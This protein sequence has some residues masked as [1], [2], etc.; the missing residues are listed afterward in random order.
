MKRIFLLII[1]ILMC[2]M[3]YA[4]ITGTKNIPADYPTLA[5]AITDL[6]TQG[7]GYGGV[8]LNLVAG[9][10]ETAPAGGYSI[11]TLTGTALSPITII[12]NG[13]TITSYSP[14]A[15][16]LLN[17]AIFKIIGVDYITIQGFTMQ[18]NTAN[19]TFTAGTNNMTEF[20]IALFYATQTDGAK[21]ITIQNNIISLNRLY[22]NS[23]GIYS[24]VRHSSTVMTTAADITS[25][26]GANDNTHIY[27]NTIT[28]VNIGIAIVGST[29]TANMNTGIDI[30][31]TSSSTANTIS[32]FG[33]T[34]S[35]SSF[36]S[37]SGSVMG[38]YV[39]NCLNTNI[40]YNSISCPGLNTAGT[41]YGVF[42]QSTGPAPT[43]G[44]PISN[45]VT[46]NNISMKSGVLSGT[47]YGMRY[48]AGSA[49][50]S[51]DLSYN[52]FSNFGYIGAG[53]GTIYG[54]YASAAGNLQNVTYNTFTNLS[55]NTTGTVYLL[56]VNGLVSL[57]TS[58]QIVHHNSI[59]TAFTK[60]SAGGIV[61][62]LYNAGASSVGTASW[63]NNNFS[64][65]TLTG[66]TT[67]VLFTQNDQVTYKY[68]HDNI[69]NNITGGT[70]AITGLT[71][72]NG[73]DSIYNNTFSGITNG[74]A[75]TGIKNGSYD[76]KTQNI[77]SN[78]IHGF[79]STGAAA[80]YGIQSAVSTTGAV[81]NIYKNNIYDL[82]DA[83]ATAASVVYGIYVSAGVTQNIYNNFISDLRTP[84]AN[85]ANPLAGIWLAS[86][87]G[88]TNNVFY[89]T[90]FLSGSSSGALFGSS[91]LYTTTAPTLDMRNNVLVNKSTPA[92]AGIT[93]A[94]RRSTAI[95]TTY[96][97]N[98]NANA[99][100]SGATE[101]ATHAVYFDGTTPLSMASYKGLVSPTDA[102]SFRELPP[103]VN[104]LT[105][106]YDVHM[107]TNIAT[108]CESGGIQ[109]A[110]P[111]AVTDD[112][113]G[114]ARTSTPDVG[115]DE[116]NGIAGGL[117]NPGGLTASAISSQQ[118]NVGFTPNFAGNNVIIVWNTSGTFTPPSGTPPSVGSLF[119][120]GTL[121]YN[122]IV[123]PVNHTGLTPGTAYYYKA[124]SYDPGSSIYSGGVTA[125]AT[126][127]V[128]PP[129]G[130]TASTISSTEIDLLYTLNAQSNNVLIATNSSSSFGVPANGTSYAAGNSLPS[131]GMVIYVGPL[132]GFNHAGLTPITEYYY[133]VWSMDAF[134][135]YS[136]TAV[137]ANATTYCTPVTSLPWHEGFENMT[138]V[139][140]DILPDC[141]A[142]K[143]L[144]GSNYS[145]AT[146]CN[147]NTAHAGTN[148]IGGSWNFDVWNF[149]PGMQLSGGVSYDFSY[150][151]KCTST[152]LG[153]NITL[154][155][156][157]T[158]TVA[159]MTNVVYATTGVNIQGWTYKKVTFTPAAS[160][161]YFFGIHDISTGQPLGIAFD[162]FTVEPTPSCDDPTALAAS[163]ITTTGVNLGWTS[164]ASAW[165]YQ[166]IPS[167]NTPAASGT[168]TTSNPTT[169]TGLTPNTSYD[170]YV[171]ANCSGTYSSWSGPITF[172]TLCTVAE[173]PF[174][175]PFAA[176]SL[177]SCW[178]IS[179][180]Q[181][182][183]F[184]HSDPIPGYGAGNVTDHTT[185]G[186]GNYAWVDG[187]GTPN[188]KGI[189]LQSPAINISTLSLPRLR[190]YI[191]NNN[192]NSALLADE[193]QLTLDIWDG[194]A[195]HMAAFT[196]AYGQN[197]PDWQEEIIPLNNYSMSGQIILRFNV[198]KGTG[199]PAFDDFILDD[200]TVEETPAC[201]FPS[202][203]TAAP[204][205][206]FANLG[207]TAGGSESSWDIEYGVSG[208]TPTGIPTNTGVSNPYHLTGLAPNTA[209]AYYVR[210]NC[211]A[212]LSA[213]VGPQPF[214]TLIPCPQPI[215]LVVKSVTETSATINWG[216][217][218]S[219]AS[220]NIEWGPEG[221]TQ[222]TGTM[223]SGITTK[224]YT[225]TGLSSGTKYDFYIQSDCGGEMSSIWSGPLTFTTACQVIS[226]YPWTEG[227]EGMATVGQ[228]ILPPCM[229]YENV[230]GT[231]GPTTTN[232]NTFWYS[233]HTGLQSIYT[234][235]NNTTWIFSPAMSLNAG[236]SYD[237]S[238]W[239][240]N[241]D[242]VL[243]VDFTMNVA[244]GTANSSAGMT[245]V[246]ASG[247]PCT[248]NTYIQ[249]KYSF[250]PSSTGVYYLGVKTAS[251]SSTQEAVNFDDFR[252]EPT[253]ACPLPAN[254]SVSAITAT[255]AGL[256]WTG[257]TTVQFDFGN[258]G[259]AAG[260]GTLT[261]SVSSN[262]FSLGGLTPAS[263]YDVYVRQDCGF[264]SFSPWFG[265]V[266][267]TT[268][269]NATPA[270]FVQNFESQTFPPDCWSSDII[271]GTYNWK[272]SS[273][274]SGFG[275]GNG[276]ALAEF[277]IMSPNRIFE[278]KTLPFNI[279]G[280]A[281][282]VLKFDYAY[283]SYGVAVDTLDVYYSTNYGN[284]YS[285]LLSMP[286]GANGIL[287]TAGAVS[288]VFTPQDNQ[289]ATQN[290]TI[291]AGT[292]MIKFKG[293]SGGGNN[294]YLDNVTVYSQLSHDAEA[295][296]VG[297]N[298]VV[299]QGTVIPTAMVRNNGT[300]SETFSVTLTIGS[301]T[302]TR[303]VTAL[304][305]G[306]AS[307]VTFTPWNAVTG[308]Y[309]ATVT[310]SLSGDLNPVNNVASKAIKVLNLNK[311]VY[312]YNAYANASPNPEGPISFNLA[313]PGTFTLIAN[314]SPLMP[315]VG[316]TW[317]NGLWYGTTVSP[318]R[319]L[320][321]NPST[322]ART[323]IGSQTVGINGL[324]Y[325][326]ANS[327]MYGIANDGISNT[328]LYSINMSTGAVTY[329][330]DCGARTLINLAINNEGQAYSLDIGNDVLGK[331]DLATGAFTEVGP[332]GFDANYYQG[333]EFDRETGDLYMAANGNG[334]SWLAWVNLTT[335][336]ALKIG[337]FEGDAEVTSLAIPYSNNKT[338]NLSSLWLEGLY[339]G[340][341]LMRQANDETGPHYSAPT[342]DRITVELHSATDYG[343]IVFTASSVNLSTSG[344]ATVSVP[345]AF[346]G[347]YYIT[348]KHRNSI[349]TTSATAVSFAGTTINQSFGLP[350]NVFGGNLLL[351][352]D[353]KYVVY[354]GDVNQDGIVDG[355]DMAPIDNKSAIFAAGYIPED[356]NGD[357]LIDGSD[358]AVADNNS[359]LFLTAQLP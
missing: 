99:L 233:P 16:G 238:F 347:S 113:D 93:V 120:G 343:T 97:T 272:H 95:L 54:I 290:L 185:G 43:T 313:S 18:E 58:N 174:T 228:K 20:G 149:T 292:N 105:T 234:Y 220:W 67:L 239:M 115:A 77:C 237:F 266:T 206:I 134:N 88:T 251:S 140:W 152:S 328:Q 203:L 331:I 52:D 36:I 214:T 342:A 325:N 37:V 80:V 250:T 221:S 119:A 35:I 198:D 318:N 356:I 10:P 108:L 252:F 144:N 15:A 104:I 339:N 227:F 96:S 38:I 291:P 30:G 171:R 114:N 338:I 163:G 204:G 298:S 294:L 59:V 136:A 283:G 44:S 253:P 40:S 351:M 335:G 172:K 320:T 229:S 246:L 336:A 63:M 284:T 269:C 76:G 307:Q 68:L 86:A 73:I 14:Q 135:Y 219:A 24:N 165:Q 74:G 322:G 168:P 188:L 299:A 123:S 87:A 153:Y 323:I 3:S 245:H 254:L 293:I 101:D 274:A 8:V 89:N 213:W 178:T 82:S 358:M 46:H 201:P 146:T 302:S 226:S 330:G 50:F 106:P 210:A 231:A 211:G 309:T 150:W 154:A 241:K 11:T 267:F 118:I 31:G 281:A 112:I 69:F 196:W 327:T 301:Y 216:E 9:H 344:T 282:P 268:L 348:I 296:S 200:V 345:P 232:L 142:H 300:T 110:T 169:V 111:F 34:G 65:I 57:A 308:D 242:I 223:V 78:T 295:L 122:G 49:L 4:A 71:F 189:T 70:G 326:K 103:F 158:Q 41:I 167:G 66:A 257:A 23:F 263:N 248:N 187:S 7:V 218:G 260:T 177:P 61:N 116:F 287:N 304:A 207:W 128:A 117:V 199:T 258:V 192:V 285:L 139:G 1:S 315:V 186:G 147:D 26:T 12:G 17:D 236:T 209:Y 276:S 22:Q 217:P 127:M 141:W 159:S 319:L 131:D 39:N 129:T 194:S 329:I 91:A 303:T 341:G 72:T 130:L 98:S 264:G 176:A 244:Y 166:V 27:S 124:F 121:L 288:G 138:T 202:A 173:T 349:E 55:L 340:I 278:L 60:T 160:G 28:N 265:P 92:G 215:D 354:G 125:T 225:L 83:G 126:P 157:S 19:T 94:Y 332:V 183:L 143:N 180:P 170:F 305:R 261:A 270:P 47:V 81:S 182:W 259:H 297:V 312:A 21:N 162:D 45:S 235:G 271:Y 256:G 164:T 29:T 109:I 193:Q 273:P 42:W 286:G 137:T 184:Q 310:T 337:E 222:G 350:S 6:N 224:P 107:K 321:I 352:V 208:F 190:F 155:Y 255:G 311:V 79:A 262:P 230:S 175:E 151:F 161:V 33:L 212:N 195:W 181:N 25:S 179:G 2:S 145:C 334:A 13:N 359:A 279:S 132:A 333:M 56:Y 75:I 5:D 148:F 53:T 197:A 314:Q 277:Y 306:Q 317:A 62:C 32:N 133:S 249:F 84:A 90:V 289:W 205:N 346:N 48:D 316:G 355:G 102:L 51:Y 247:I 85:T 275:T 191:F 64:N 156:G 280:L 240:Q 353:G 324:S 243:P 357:G 100:Y